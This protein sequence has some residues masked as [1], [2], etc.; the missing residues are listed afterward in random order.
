MWW[1]KKAGD[2]PVFDLWSKMI[3]L[4]NLLIG[5]AC[6]NTLSRKRILKQVL[7]K[8]L[9]GK[10]CKFDLIFTLFVINANRVK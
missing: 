7:A 3:E 2:H 9:T 10:S 8:Q 5:R 4:H 6:L 1:V